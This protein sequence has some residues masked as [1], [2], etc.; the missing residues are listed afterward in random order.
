MPEPKP[1]KLTDEQLGELLGLKPRQTM[2]L[3]ALP[4][5]KGGMQV[6][7]EVPRIW[8]QRLLGLSARV[9]RSFALD[10]HGRF[11][12]EHCSGTR[13]IRS[14]A[15]KFAGRFDVGRDD[16]RRR[17]LAFVQTLITKGLV[18]IPD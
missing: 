9:P 11:V 8:W 12:Y 15:N 4:G 5:G 16:A 1:D 6:T 7:V 14:I 3:S 17:V 10:A 2:A 13:P 18:E